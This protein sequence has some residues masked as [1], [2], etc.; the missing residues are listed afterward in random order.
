MNRL[1]TRDP[2]PVAIDSKFTRI[3]KGV[4]K[5]TYGIVR[6]VGNITKEQL[7]RPDYSAVLR[8]TPAK[9]QEELAK[10][11]EHLKQAAASLGRLKRRRDEVSAFEE[12]LAKK[13]R[14]D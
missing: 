14:K 5:Y 12:R 8:A 7:G 3:A 11:S 9:V 4:Y 1:R 10:L 13:P 2:V 6:T